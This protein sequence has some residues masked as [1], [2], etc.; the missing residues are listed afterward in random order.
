MQYS[1]ADDPVQGA[2]A[3]RAAA[4]TMTADE[5]GL[6]GS[7]GLDE[8]PAIDPAAE[9]MQPVRVEQ[10]PGRNEPCYC[11]SGKKVKLCH[12]R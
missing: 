11:G 8:A 6:G 9:T 4:A 3:M 7:G 2:S 5:Y 1:A 10:M 12:G